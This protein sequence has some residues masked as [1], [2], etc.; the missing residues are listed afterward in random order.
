MGITQERGKRGEDFAASF[1]LKNGFRIVERNVRTPFGEIDL[2][3][4][5]ATTTVFVE[6]KYRASTAFG[7]PEEVVVGKKLMRM[8][9]A[10]EWYVTQHKLQGAYRLDVVG[11]TG[12]PPRCTHLVDV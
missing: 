1:L 10:A 7:Q 5:D 3:C 2:V 8:R 12:D 6:V 11:I 4:N 9:H